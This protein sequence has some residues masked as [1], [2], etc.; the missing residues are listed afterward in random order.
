MKFKNF[1][2]SLCFCAYLFSAG[3]VGMEFIEYKVEGNDLVNFIKAVSAKR[4]NPPNDE[5]E[6]KI[7]VGVSLMVYAHK[8]MKNDHF[9]EFLL[10]NTRSRERHI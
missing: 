5:E 8:I 9:Y 6:F 10:T 7:L 3:L 4:D 2:A 1:L